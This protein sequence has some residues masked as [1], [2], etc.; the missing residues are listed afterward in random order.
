MHALER[1]AATL[2]ARQCL[3]PPDFSMHVN[4]LFLAFFFFKEKSK[5]FLQAHKCPLTAKDCYTT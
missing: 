3:N 4:L 1:R 5:L 2:P